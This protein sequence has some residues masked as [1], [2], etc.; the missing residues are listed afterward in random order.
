[1]CLWSVPPP[2]RP[3]PC[4]LL[5]LL[6]YRFLRTCNFSAH[7]ADAFDSLRAVRAFT[8]DLCSRLEQNVVFVYHL[9]K[10]IYLKF[11]TLYGQTCNPTGTFDIL[12]SLFTERVVKMP[13]HSHLGEIKLDSKRLTHAPFRSSVRLVLRRGDTSAALEC[14]QMLCFWEDE[15]G[16]D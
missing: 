10:T 6:T 11:L 5:P 16:E 3:A 12:I 13:E 7:F 1:M 2:D 9:G 4:A 15:E 8:E 14:F